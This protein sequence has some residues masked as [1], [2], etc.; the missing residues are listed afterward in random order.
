MDEKVDKKEK[1]KKEIQGMALGAVGLFVLI[2][3]LSYRT[4]DLSFNSFSSDARVRNFGGRLGAEMSDLLL[5][6][7]GLAGYLVPGALLFL[8]YLFLRFKEV[9]WRAYKWFA[10]AGLIV[11][12]SSLFA[13]NLEFT[14]LF[15]QRVPTGGAVGYQTASCTPVR[16]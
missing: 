9:K 1:L 13:F 3:L 7:T 2:A 14:S 15:G 11:S 4:D 5:Q 12:L 8:A 10:Y 16:V 6:T